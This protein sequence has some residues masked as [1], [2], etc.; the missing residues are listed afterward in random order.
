MEVLANAVRQKKKKIRGI[1]IGKEDI[2][3]PLITD[4]IIIYVKKSKIIYRQNKQ[5]NKNL[6]QI[7]SYSQVARH[8]V[9]IQK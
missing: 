8:K 5:I 9:I 3:L 1:Q 2:K 4:D 6:E 7:S